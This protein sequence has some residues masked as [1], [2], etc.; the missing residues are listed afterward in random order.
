MFHHRHAGNRKEPLGSRKSE[1]DHADRLASILWE[2]SRRSG[3][4]RVRHQA[5]SAEA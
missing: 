4:C 2:G 1:R 5:L 3:Q